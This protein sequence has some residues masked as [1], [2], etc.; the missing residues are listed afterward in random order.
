MKLTQPCLFSATMFNLSLI[1]HMQIS[2]TPITLWRPY[3]TLD[4]N[5]TALV[6][7]DCY[8]IA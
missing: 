1:S 5:T 3:S 8:L 2:T 6:L 4:S 7:I